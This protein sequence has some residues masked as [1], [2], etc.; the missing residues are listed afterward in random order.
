MR[1]FPLFAFSDGNITIITRG[2]NESQAM[3]YAARNNG[4]FKRGVTIFPVELPINAAELYSS[5]HEPAWLYRA[6]LWLRKAEQKQAIEMGL[7]NILNSISS[8]LKFEPL[9]YSEN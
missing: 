3:S 6:P 9:L 2:E 1:T 5:N 4:A 7:T 8:H